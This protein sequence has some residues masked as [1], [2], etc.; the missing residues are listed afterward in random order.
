MKCAACCLNF[1][2]A[3]KAK[4][5]NFSVMITAIEV[6]MIMGVFV[7]PVIF[8]PKKKNNLTVDAHELSAEYGVDRDG[9]LVKLEHSKE[10]H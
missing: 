9:F 1:G 8:T 4:Q 10:L 5:V 6:L 7:L 2:F 3:N